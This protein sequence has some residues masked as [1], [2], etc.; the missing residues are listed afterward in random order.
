M[1]RNLDPVIQGGNHLR[2]E[3]LDPDK[4]VRVNDL[5]EVTNP[6]FFVRN[7][8]PTPDGLLSNE[9]FGI[10][11]YDRANTFA[12]ID[13]H[14]SFLNPLIY[15]TWCKVDSNIKACVHG[16]KSFV[17]NSKGELEE[18]MEHGDTGIAFLRKNIHKLKIKRDR[19]SVV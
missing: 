4:L 9:I 2:A 15:K 11:K 12:Y 13:L 6:V 16:T 3:L 17:I 18:D 14:E 8:V 7:S 1:P 10:T 5:K 19:K